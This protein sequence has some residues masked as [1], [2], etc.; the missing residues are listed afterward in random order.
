MWNP[1]KRGGSRL[2]RSVVRASEIGYRMHAKSFTID[3][4]DTVLGGRNICDQYFGAAEDIAFADIDILS[5]GTSLHEVSNAFD[6][7]WNA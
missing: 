5:I 2:I 6:S 4:R 1:W 7:Y 3:T